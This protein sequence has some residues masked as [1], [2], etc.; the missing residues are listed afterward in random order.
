MRW[1][2]RLKSPSLIAESVEDSSLPSAEHHTLHLGPDPQGRQAWVQIEVAD[3]WLIVTALA[4][5]A[6][7]PGVRPDHPEWQNRAYLSVRLNP[8]HDHALRW[9]Y[10]VDDRGEVTGEAHWTTQGEELTDVGANELK[11]PPAADGEFRYREDATF[12]ARLKIPADSLWAQSGEPL[13]FSVS[14]GFHEAHLVRSLAWPEPVD[15]TDTPLVYGDLYKS[16]PCVR[17]TEIDFRKPVWGVSPITF[18]GLAVDQ[19]NGQLEI[20]A[21]LPGDGKYPQAPVPLSIAPGEFS[22]EI[23]LVFSFRA[24]WANGSRNMAMLRLRLVDAS[25]NLLWAAEYPFGFDHGII[26]REQFGANG[27]TRAERPDPSAPDFLDKFR[28]FIL[29]GLPDYRLRTT[30]EGAASDFV[31]ADPEGA[32]D[33]DLSAADSLRRVAEVLSGRFPD[34]QDALCAAAMWIHHPQVTTHSSTWSRV[35]NVSSVETIPRLAGCFCG[36]TARLGA[37]LA[38]QIGVC[39]DVP[40]KGLSMGLRGHLCSLVETPIG[41]VV[42]DGMLGLWFHTRDNTRLATLEEMRLEKEIAERVWYAPRA[43]GHEFFYGT[44]NQLIR[45]WK[46]GPLV[47]PSE[48]LAESEAR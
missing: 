21:D 34:W 24:K 15:W 26:V 41:R 39:L 19:V 33:I 20:E 28:A 12:L 42:I 40:L 6:P 8:G 36:D 4:E 2:C 3:G 37:A 29:S 9:L 14:T 13:G 7:D 18:S 46:S 48:N 23:P 16:A 31:L 17:V 1:P 11:A 45:P 47:W 22:L 10:A 44:D 35:S 5:G 43:H 32:D 38:E 27:G 25:G 30:R